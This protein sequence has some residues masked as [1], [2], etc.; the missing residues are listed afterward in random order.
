MKTPPHWVC[1][2]VWLFLICLL[3][4]QNVKLKTVRRVLA[5]IFA[6]NV[7]RACTRTGADV[8]PAVL[9]GSALSMAL[10]SVQ[11]SE[12]KTQN[13]PVSTHL[14]VL[15]IL[16]NLETFTFQMPQK[17]W[18]W[19]FCIHEKGIGHTFY[20]ID[21]KSCLVHDCVLLLLHVACPVSENSFAYHYGDGPV[22]SETTKFWDSLHFCPPTSVLPFLWFLNHRWGKRWRKACWMIRVLLISWENI[23][24]KHSTNGVSLNT[25][26]GS[27]RLLGL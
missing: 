21:L 1:F 22:K 12:F 3:S 8:S 7:R 6:Q 9:M 16:I 26:T 18:F 27:S 25:G 10:W 24:D 5:E 15:R 17:N 20:W 23:S 19:C 4:F 13:P 2:T 14:F 11:V